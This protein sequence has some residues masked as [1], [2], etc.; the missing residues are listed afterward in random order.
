MRDAVAFSDLPPVPVQAAPVQ[1]ATVQDLLRAVESDPAGKR[2]IHLHTSKLPVGMLDSGRM[3]SVIGFLRKT[4][5]K[6]GFGEVALA[7]NRDVV[8]WVT[9][10]KL[11]AL[12]GMC[13]KVENHFCGDGEFQVRNFYDEIYF[14]TIIDASTE[15][16][17]FRAFAAST[18]VFGPVP[19]A[20]AERRKENIPLK[21]FTAVCEL[22]RNSDISSHIF[23]QPIYALGSGGARPIIKFVEFYVG[24]KSFEDDVCP[25]F[26]ITGDPWLFTRLT[27]EFDRA[28]LRHVRREISR[29][30]LSSFS[31]NLNA[32]SV[33]TSEF[34]LFSESL[35]AGVAS[36]VVLELG[37]VSIL[38]DWALAE[39]V[40]QLARQRGFRLCLDGLDLRDF[41]N[42]RLKHLDFDFVKL[43][44]SLEAMRDQP[45]VERAVRT[46]TEIDRDRVV[47]SMCDSPHAFSFARTAGIRYVQGRLADSH[48]RNGVIF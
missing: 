5:R 47:L 24:M 42:L 15:L 17:R 19:A 21:D 41:A 13:R 29:F 6:T 31:L 8:A 22:V 2:I 20:Q 11:S 32:T 12:I 28:M 40:C 36:R 7:P 10:T 48:V 27:G 18:M 44:W 4:I 9:G 26:S 45:L 35:P 33:M 34:T 1:A 38:Q 43:K 14:Y 39:E 16:G 30:P 3:R 25:Q 23:N 37:K 46:M